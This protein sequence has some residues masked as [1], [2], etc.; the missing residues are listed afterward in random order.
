VLSS[1]RNSERGGSECMNSSPHL[2]ATRGNVLAFSLTS[3]IG[4]FFHN[5]LALYFDPRETIM[6]FLQKSILMFQHSSCARNYTRL[7]LEYSFLSSPHD[8]YKFSS[9]LTG[10]PYGSLYPQVGF[11]A[12]FPYGSHYPQVGFMGTF[13]YGSHPV[14]IHAGPHPLIILYYIIINQTASVV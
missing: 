7:S 8:I 11:M 5:P 6:L 14:S 4:P 2:S 13:P 10:S 1:A 9:Y 12:T 3:E